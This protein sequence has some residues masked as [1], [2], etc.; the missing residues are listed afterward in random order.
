MTIDQANMVMMKTVQIWINFLLQE[1]REKFP[2]L[3]YELI[4]EKSSVLLFSLQSSFIIYT[5]IKTTRFVHDLKSGQM[6]LLE[7]SS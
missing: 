2:G 6:L 4:A 7:F 3:R 5:L 1:P